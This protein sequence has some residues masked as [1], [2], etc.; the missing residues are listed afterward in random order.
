[1]G[2]GR[3]QGSRNK[4]KSPL[5]ELFDEYT[6]PMMRKCISLAA[7]GDVRAIRIFMERSHPV[8]R[9]ASVRITLPRMRTVQDLNKAA[10][11]VMR[12]VGRGEIT[13]AEGETLMNSLEIQSRMIARGQ[14]ESSVE[15]PAPAN[16]PANCPDESQIEYVHAA[17]GKS[18][19]SSRIEPDGQ[20]VWVDPPEGGKAG[21]PVEEEDEPAP[22]SK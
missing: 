18:V 2:R 22:V 13:P 21:E 14:M 15:Q 9:D 16:C 8:R 7:Q 5:Q 4:A 1:M 12:S 17:D 6:V 19:S 10:E 20:Q 3:P 11:K